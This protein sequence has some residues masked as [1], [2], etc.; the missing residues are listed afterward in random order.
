MNKSILLIKMLALTFLMIL[1]LADVLVRVEEENI[2][3]GGNSR[4]TKK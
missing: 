2:G 3:I 4:P 1:I